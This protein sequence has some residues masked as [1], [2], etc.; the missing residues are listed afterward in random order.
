MEYTVYRLLDNTILFRPAFDGLLFRMGRAL[1]GS[2]PMEP[3][4]SELLKLAV[5][6][7]WQGDLWHCLLARE[8]AMSENPFSLT[9][10]RRRAQRDSLFGFAQVDMNSYQALFALDNPNPAFRAIRNFR[11][12]SKAPTAAALHIMELGAKLAAA[13]DTTD[14]LRTLCLHYEKAGVGILGLGQVFR[15]EA[16][17]GD[18]ILTP[19]EDRRNVML[20]HLVGYESQKKLLLDNTLPFLRGRRA[21]NVLL[22]GDSGTGKSSSIQAIA[23]ELAP[24]GLRVIEL[25]R[26]QFALIPAL[27]NKIKTRNYRFILLLDDLSFEETEVE[28]KHLK[29]VMEGGAEA[30][31]ENVLVYATS[32]CRYLV[33]DSGADRTENREEKLSLVGRFG[34]QIHYPTPTLEEYHTIVRELAARTGTLA[35]MDDAQLLAAADTWQESHESH[36][37]R[38]AQ[39]FINDLICQSDKGEDE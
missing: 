32:N 3:A 15:A 9:Y 11:Q 1:D 12:V 14:M 26:N 36:S 39:Q 38:S 8:L 19:V 17:N 25:Y 10:E 22:Y 5:S 6:Q 18:V 7:G 24:Q 27:L 16:Q 2:A 37:G 13:K 29:A 34:L 28:Y 31:P 30:A 23:N 33:K 4:L 35:A 21:N 20:S